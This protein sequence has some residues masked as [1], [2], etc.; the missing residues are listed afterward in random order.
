MPAWL[1]R[2]IVE[3]LTKLITPELIKKAELAVCCKVKGLMDGMADGI[4]KDALESGLSVVA[5]ALG[6]DLSACPA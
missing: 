1:E 5:A 4:E 3:E 6:A 2:L